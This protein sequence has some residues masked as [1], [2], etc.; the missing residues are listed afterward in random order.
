LKATT[1][2]CST[3][4]C[5]RPSQTR[6][7]SEGGTR[8]WDPSETVSGKGHAPTYLPSSGS[9][10]L[11]P[12]CPRRAACCAQAWG[13]IVSR[14]GGGQASHTQ[15]VRV[16]D[17][18]RNHRRTSCPMNCRSRAYAC[19]QS[20]QG[21]IYFHL[22]HSRNLRAGACAQMRSDGAAPKAADLER[23]REERLTSMLA[24]AST[25]MNDTAAPLVVRGCP[26]PFI[27]CNAI[28]TMNGKGRNQALLLPLGSL[29]ASQS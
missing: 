22:V 4:R 29:L 20:N 15:H 9:I 5:V 7:T 10:S 26:N 21:S 1:Y 2:L 17:R 8:F 13:N 18:A 12:A 28:A 3:R 14:G 16:E 19:V 27:F 11:R 23:L 6:P 25:A 24:S